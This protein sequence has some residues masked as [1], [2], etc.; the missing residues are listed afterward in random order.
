MRRMLG[1]FLFLCLTPCM[2]LGAIAFLLCD[3][4]A[5]GWRQIEEFLEDWERNA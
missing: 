5:Y 4:T 3:A 2:V 1:W